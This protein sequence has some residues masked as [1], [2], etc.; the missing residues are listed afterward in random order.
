MRLGLNFHLSPCF[1]SAFEILLLFDLLVLNN[2]FP[3][4]KEHFL[5]V[6]R[7]FRSHFVHYPFL[8]NLANF[9]NC[10]EEFKLGLES[11]SFSYPFNFCFPL[12]PGSSFQKSFEG[13]NLKPSLTKVNCSLFLP[14]LFPF[15]I[16]ILPQSLKHKSR[17]YFFSSLLYQ[18][19]KSSSSLLLKLFKV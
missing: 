6:N 18:N 9:S 8:L 10:F 17:V 1:E 5:F 16:Y 7:E 15:Q 12:D 3:K 13:S 4:T 11:S 14:L 19:L 2:H